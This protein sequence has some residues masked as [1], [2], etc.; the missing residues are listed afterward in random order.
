MCL[1]LFYFFQEVNDCCQ[2]TNEAFLTVWSEQSVP[3][4]N[5]DCGANFKYGYYNK[6]CDKD[7]MDKN[8][9]TQTQLDIL[10][11]PKKC[12]K[13]YTKSSM[14]ICHNAKKIV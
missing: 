14:F 4:V 7:S 5:A 1:F 13:N 8:N 9:S 12:A 2:F 10:C 11:M 3:T 6:Q